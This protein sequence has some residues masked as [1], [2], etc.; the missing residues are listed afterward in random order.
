M[1]EVSE[2]EERPL[3]VGNNSKVEEPYPLRLKGNVIKGFGR[4]GKEL[5]IPTANLPEEVSEY[6][7]KFLESGILYG[8]ASVGT[9][10]TVHPMVMSL[11]WNPFFKNEKRSAEVHII[12]KYFEDFYEKELRILVAG[13]IRPEKNYT[14]LEALINDIN[15]DIKVAHNCLAR[16]AYDQLKLD[17][18]L[19]PSV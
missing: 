11:G 15:F 16:A 6:A 9:N 17:P 10:A 7:G 3:V 2:T 18:F 8:W 1:V 4:G 13:Y 12:H 14:S 19:Q 5:G